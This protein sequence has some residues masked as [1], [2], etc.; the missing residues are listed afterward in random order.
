MHNQN[1]KFPAYSYVPRGPWPHPKSSPE[2]HSAGRVDQRPEPI[3]ADDWAAS[4]AYC[5]GVALFNAGYYWEAHEAWEGLWLA[6]QRRGPTAEVLKGLIKLAAAGVKV[7]ERQLHGVQ[8]HALRAADCFQAARD[9][10]GPR[11]LGLDLDVWIRTALAVAEH[12]PCDLAPPGAAVAR[13]FDFL[14]DPC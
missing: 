10:A 6:H 14:I 13:V 9:Q 8:I 4:E 7:R 3:A 11:Q 2:G 12:P 1:Y 5:L